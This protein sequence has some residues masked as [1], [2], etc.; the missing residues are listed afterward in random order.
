MMKLH[1][2]VSWLA[3]GILMSGTLQAVTDLNVT[4][5]YSALRDGNRRYISGLTNLS[6]R[7]FPHQNKARLDALAT[8]GQH[9]FAT[10]MT[11]SD[12]R[13]PPELV[14]DTGL[15]D[16][17]VI[18]VA[19]NIS[20]VDE[21]GS[22]EYGV[23][24]LSTPV[25]VIMGHSSCGAVTAVGQG[26][27]LHG[28]IPELVDNI[29]PA[30]RKARLQHPGVSGAELVEFAVVENVWQSIDDLFATSEEV[31]HLVENGSLRVLG[32]VYEL[33]TG[34]VKWLGEHPDQDVL[35]SYSGGGG[36][37]APAAASHGAA[38]ESHGD[39]AAAPEHGEPSTAAARTTSTRSSSTRAQ[40][41]HSSSRT[42]LWLIT[43]VLLSV[44]GIYLV[45]T[46]T[47]FSLENL[48]IRTKILA[49]SAVVS[50]VF[51]V[52]LIFASNRMALI[53]D[54]F[55]E[56]AELYLPLIEKMS[57]ITVHQLEQELSV[58]AMFLA[59][60][61]REYE[62]MEHQEE[63][64]HDWALQV[65]EEILEAER[66][67]EEGEQF[68]RN[69]EDLEYLER[70][71][72]HMKVI[73]EEHA[74]YDQHGE[75]I[76]A[77]LQAGEFRQAESLEAGLQSEGQD[78][79]HE[80]E[81]FLLDVEHRADS[82]ALVVETEQQAATV[83][84]MV[85]SIVALAVGIFFS[86]FIS[87]RITAAVTRIIEAL[88][89]V[90]NRD[91]RVE[92]DDTARDELGEIATQVN[93][94]VSNVATM[95]RDIASSSEQVGSASGQISSASEQL[96]AGAE[97]QQAQLSEV[98]TTME[99][100]SAMILEASKNANETRE[101]AQNTGN[102]AEDGRDVVSKTV[103]GFKTVAQTV[104]RAAGQIES[105]NK[106]SEEIGNVIQVIDD[107]ADQTNLLALNANIE[108]ARA[109]DAGRGF[110]VVADEV[111][112]LAERTVTATAEISSMIE[113]IQNEI[114]GAVKSMT[115]IQEQSKEGLDLVGKSDESL[116]EI[117]GSITGVVTAVEQIAT[118]TNEQSSGAEEISK[119]IEGVTTVAKESASSA[120]ELAASA[121]QLNKEVTGL[122]QLIGQ[123]KV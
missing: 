39:A 102:T 10:I 81:V 36:H 123:F 111:R 50:A 77:L 105:L 5:A 24:H 9:P 91:M 49:L 19:G 35:L 87:G 51:L 86:I 99:Q 38:V 62:E 64:F 76:I 109:G 20:D 32:A 6:A 47:K 113:S 84:V 14:F 112:K 57:A 56:I 92:L 65:Q 21:V 43:I 41:E 17:F 23:G 110:A 33:G 1:K 52:A 85:L 34:R 31:R 93:N 67:I 101:T 75:D 54:G 98:A 40:T 97:E 46:K 116:K 53:G 82:L 25:L 60:K 69:A 90:A 26:A 103:I 78:L 73:E 13:V 115:E 89:K 118:S 15:G 8:G 58:G 71:L 119:N 104:E 55:A 37:G 106:R 79:G 114:Q 16:V 100:M 2:M 74:Q 66:L 63:A 4:Q 107:I 96:A 18:R 72:E 12:S 22:I 29:A 121:E 95:I 59:E 88:K 27:E 83:A 45:L 11:C 117:S 44:G 68:A 48:K 122:N 3:V 61:N 7:S 42:E 108:A 80:L 120:Q 30:A 94:T 70:A 28:S